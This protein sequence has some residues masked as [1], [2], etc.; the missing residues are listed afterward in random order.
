[1]TP[2][3]NQII[4]KVLAMKT[5]KNDDKNKD[6]II[7]IMRETQKMR[8]DEMEK[9]TAN[10]SFELDKFL[11]KYPKLLAYDGLLVCIDNIFSFLLFI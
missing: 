5:W 3:S 2:L 9:E 1:M 4:F 10:G 7:Q 11:D 8:F 6:T